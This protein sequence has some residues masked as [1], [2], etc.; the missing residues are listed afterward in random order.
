MTFIIEKKQMV[1]TAYYQAVKALSRD[2]AE[3]R[4]YTK[5]I[6]INDHLI[7][8]MTNES[9][10][11]FNIPAEI[12]VPETGLYKPLSV[13]KSQII[14]EK[15]S[16]A[17]IKDYPDILDIIHRTEHKFVCDIYFDNKNLSAHYFISELLYVLGNQYQTRINP[18]YVYQ[19]LS[20]YP[21]KYIEPLDRKSVV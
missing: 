10:V 14:L 3:K 15:N 17:T 16:E 11:Y 20:I 2:K 9:L 7:C 8:G 4:L 13:S 18:E 5:H 6:M 12:N 1:F 19:Y 21:S